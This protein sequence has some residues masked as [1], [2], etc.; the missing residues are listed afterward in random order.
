MAAGASTWV[1]LDRRYAG[2]RGSLVLTVV[3]L[4]D[5]RSQGVGRGYEIRFSNPTVAEP[6]QG[7]RKEPEARRDPMHMLRLIQ[8]PLPCFVKRMRKTAS[9]Q[10]P[11][12]WILPPHVRLGIVLLTKLDLKVRE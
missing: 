3:R 6:C 4:A 8:Y 10:V 1:C 11:T 12:F 5:E 9:A 7:Q 2:A